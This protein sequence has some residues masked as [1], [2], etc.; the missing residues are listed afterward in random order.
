MR[1]EGIFFNGVY[2]SVLEEILQIQSVLPELILFLQPFKG[3][4]ILA[5]EHNPPTVDDPVRL[6][7]SVTTDLPTVRYQAEIVGWDDKRTIERTKRKVIERLLW[8]LQ[9]GEGGLYDKSQSDSGESVNL[10]HVRRVERL[11]E[12]FGVERLVKTIGGGSV[13]PNRT[14]A[15]G[16]TYVRSALSDAPAA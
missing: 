12:P 6:F 5:L 9:P 3:Q 11:A 8:T 16:W 13:S 1:E 7:M 4:A 14:Q 2:E 15:G 10:L